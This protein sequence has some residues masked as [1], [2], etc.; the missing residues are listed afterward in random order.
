MSFSFLTFPICQHHPIA[1]ATVEPSSCTPQAIGLPEKL[2]L[3][4]AGNASL[5][6]Q[7]RDWSATKLIYK[8]P[9]QHCLQPI[10][11]F[12]PATAVV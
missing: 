5:T 9:Q 12:S 7:K 4:P 2:Q 3:L 1:L 11:V 8:I 6:P 10:T